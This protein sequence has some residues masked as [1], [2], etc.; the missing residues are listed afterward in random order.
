VFNPHDLVVDMLGAGILWRA[1]QRIENEIM[2]PQD[3]EL[4]EGH[5]NFQERL[6]KQLTLFNL[7]HTALGRNLTSLSGGEKTRLYLASC[8][9]DDADFLILDEPTNHLDS[10]S[11]HLLYQAIQTWPHGLLVVSH[12]RVLLNLMESIIELNTLGLH[13][14]GGNYDAYQTQ[15]ALEL[16]AQQ[17]QLEDA[18]K[19]LHTTRHT[20]QLSKEKH[21]QRRVQGER[22]AQRGSIDKLTA[23]SKRGRSEQ[24]Q[25][26]MLIQEERQTHAAEQ[27]VQ[28]MKQ[29]IELIETIDIELPDTYVPAKKMV[30]NIEDVSFSYPGEKPLFKHFN[31]TLQG[32]ERIALVGANGSGKSTLLQ[33]IRKQ[34]LT[35]QG[36]IYLG[37]ETVGYLDQNVEFLRSN[38][39]ILENFLRLNPM[40]S[41]FAA[42][43]YLAQ[44]LFRNQAALKL[45][46][47]LSGGERLR[48]GLACIL[49]AKKP[50]QLLLLDEPTN[51]LDLAS[52]AHVE[53]ILSYYQGAVIVVSHDQ[54]FLQNINCERIVELNKRNTSE[55]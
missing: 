51:H 4:L 45:V 41:E 5:W 31:L 8:F 37:V 6:Y 48:V 54:N 43:S 30:L 17:Q 1:W 33:L 9:V 25:H 42:R 46:S 39:S 3:L 55:G 27:K 26:R 35:Q 13:S 11:R 32:P 14:Y 34:L 15:K 19:A 24:S 49:Y 52:I 28:T 12:D 47:F 16:A 21:A 38:E 40:V 2:E 7:G 29:Q 10:D 23:N 18:Q 36:E 20:L 53:M 50:P 44:F 22:L